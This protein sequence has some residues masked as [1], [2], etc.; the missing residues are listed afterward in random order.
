MTYE[1]VLTA[2]RSCTQDG[3]CDSCFLRNS[4]F[5][6]ACVYKLHEMGADAIDN[7]LAQRDSLQKYQNDILSLNDC[8]SCGRRNCEFRP[9]PGEFCR[10]N[11]AFYLGRKNDDDE[12]S[13]SH[14]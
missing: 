8:N 6:H 5:G 7:L 12:P 3:E 13:E 4:P 14:S 11:C 1:E 9:R 10:V 2:L